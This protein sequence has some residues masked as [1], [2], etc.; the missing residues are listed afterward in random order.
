[1][2]GFLLIIAIWAI[3]QDFG[4]LFSGRATDPNSGPLIA[5]MAMALLAPAFVKT[6]V[7]A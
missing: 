6:G 5:V 7:V 2:I 1:M 3:G 4:L